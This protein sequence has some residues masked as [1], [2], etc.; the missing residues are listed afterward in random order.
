[1]M[2]FSDDGR[3]RRYARLQTSYVSGCVK[4]RT[5]SLEDTERNLAETAQSRSGGFVFES[6]KLFNVG[7]ILR[8]ELRIS[9]WDKFLL[10]QPRAGKPEGGDRLNVLGKVVLSEMGIDSGYDIGVCF[11]NLDN[12][13]RELLLRHLI[14][15]MH[16]ALSPVK[17][18]KPS[19]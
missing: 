11:I 4:T 15:G 6:D 16:A 5:G 19:R 13:R 8:I 10:A 2:M 12:G 1:M 14:A 17:S 18:V 9:G 7:D 3:K